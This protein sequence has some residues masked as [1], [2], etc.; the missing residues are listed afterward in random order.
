MTGER[1][2]LNEAAELLGVHYMTAYRYVRLGQLP[3]EKSGGSW[4]V[5]RADL[6]ALREGLAGG[7]G[8]KAGGSGSGSG[9]SRR[10]PWAERLEARLIAGDL[11]GAWGV[12]ESA[13]AAGAELDEVYLDILSPAMQSIGM[14]WSMGE[15]DIAVEHR[16]SGIAVRLIGRLGPRFARR[17]RSRGTIVIGAPSGERHSLP[18]ALLADLLRGDGWEVS[19]LGAD[20]PAESFVRACAE[21]SDLVAVGVSVSTPELLESAAAT[22]AALRAALPSTVYVAVG[23]AAVADQAHAQS[24]G[25]DGWAPSARAFMDRLNGVDRADTA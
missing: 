23:G 4:Q 1:L 13:L 21:V 18:L 8:P 16:A 3:A 7:S 20:T 19:D 14:R 15:L 2:S 10:A 5:R 25:A 6:D 9:R 24:M 17:G 22:C 11:G 12:I